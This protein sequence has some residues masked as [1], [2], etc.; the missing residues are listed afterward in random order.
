MVTYL[1]SITCTLSSENI[2]VNGG[3]VP[4]LIVYSVKQFQNFLPDLSKTYGLG[5]RNVK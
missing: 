5:A 1:A 4:A 2:V 3:V